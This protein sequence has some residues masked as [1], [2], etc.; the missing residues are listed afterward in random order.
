MN[1][2]TEVISYQN[3]PQFLAKTETL[4]K[5]MQTL[6][7]EEAKAVWKCNDKIAE[8]NLERL[9]KMNLHRNLTP[10]LLSY[11]GIQYQYMAPQIF[12]DRQW[13]YVQEHLRILSGFYGILRPMDGIVP[14][15]LEM[16]SK[17][18]VDGC[19]TLYE[20]WADNLYQSLIKETDCILN[21]ASKEYSKA[22]EKYLTSDIRMITCVFG[23]WKDGKIIQKGTQAK[24]ARG[25]MVRYLAASEIE[26]PDQIK[27]FCNLDFHFSQTHSNET[28]FIFLRNV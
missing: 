17:I 16:Q 3:E 9:H 23:E 10:A 26:S 22:L 13:H 28:E 4:M 2:N 6:S 15:R 1:I 27:D 19:T 11:E 8:L 25:E 7:Y 12:S 21:L 24:M 14:Y 20:Y 5:W 18:N